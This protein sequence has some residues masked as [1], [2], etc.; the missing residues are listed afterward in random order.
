MYPERVLQHVKKGRAVSE[1]DG[2]YYLYKVCP[3]NPAKRKEFLG[4]INE[5]GRIIRGGK[6][7]LQVRSKAASTVLTSVLA[8]IF[9]IVVLVS[10]IS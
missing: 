9:T 5:D 1:V 6:D 7:V 3:K 4:L 10:I 8:V 2:T